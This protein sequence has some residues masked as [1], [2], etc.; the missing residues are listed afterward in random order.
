LLRLIH[1]EKALSLNEM[2]KRESLGISLVRRLRN[3][4]KFISP[5]PYIMKPRLQLSLDSK[6]INSPLAYNWVSQYVVITHFH[7]SKRTLDTWHAKEGLPKYKIGR[8][9]LYKETDLHAWIEKHKTDPGSK[10][11]NHNLYGK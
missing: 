3:S 6:D 5:K 7:I 1:G 2:L 8:L 10:N 11:K 4:V 9:V